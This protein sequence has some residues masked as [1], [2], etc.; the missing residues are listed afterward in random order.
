MQPPYEIED[1]TQIFS[2]GLVIYR[3]LVEHNL[4]EMI[5]IAGGPDAAMPALQNA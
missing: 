5:R 2:P 4:Q 3:D 1:V